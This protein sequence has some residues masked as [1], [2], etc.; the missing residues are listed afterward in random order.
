MRNASL[1]LVLA[2]AATTLLGGCGLVYKVDVY[3]GSLLDKKQ[4][5]QLKTGLTKRQVHP[6]VAVGLR[7]FGAEARR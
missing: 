1:A 5:D 6:S 4:V 7:R 2:L 3:Q